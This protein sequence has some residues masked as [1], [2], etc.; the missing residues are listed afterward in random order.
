M[1]ISVKEIQ[2]IADEI[3]FMQDGAAAFNAIDFTIKV[4]HKTWFGKIVTRSE[5]DNDTYNKKV[6]E[7][8]DS[9]PYLRV[10]DWSYAM[11]SGWGDALIELY[12]LTAS[13][14]T[15]VEIHNVNAALAGVL[16]VMRRRLR[17]EQ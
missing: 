3:A 6:K 16:G 7:L 9:N 2:D 14:T 12:Q 11:R 15:A 13:S 17:D 4:E 8:M 5:T 1:R 10:H